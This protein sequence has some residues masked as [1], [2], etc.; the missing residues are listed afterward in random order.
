MAITLTA[1][2]KAQRQRTP[3]EEIN[4]EVIEAVNE[5]LEYCQEHPDERVSAS[6]ETVA[7]AEEFLTD[8][9][10][11]AYQAQPRLVVTGNTTRKGQARFIVTLW[12]ADTP[13]TA[14]TAETDAA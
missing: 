1:V 11:Y 6:F 5:A 3:I 8:A 7:E 14:A 2:P 9:R 13:E 4:P 12:G 10:S